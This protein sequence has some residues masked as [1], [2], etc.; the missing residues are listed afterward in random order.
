MTTRVIIFS[1]VVPLARELRRRLGETDLSVMD[2]SVQ[3]DELPVEI[4][5]K[6]DERQLLVLCY[7]VGTIQRAV[8]LAQLMKRKNPQLKA[9]SYSSEAIQ[10]AVFDLYI[11]VSRH[12]GRDSCTNLIA[13]I[14]KFPST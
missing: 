8:E 9:A 13:E 12:G 4:L 7:T 1:T 2:Y 3:E 6:P 5:V 10:N 14:R 11:P